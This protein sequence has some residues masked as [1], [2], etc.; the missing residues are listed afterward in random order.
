MRLEVDKYLNVSYTQQTVP[1]E[2]QGGKVLSF[3]CMLSKEFTNTAARV[4]VRS[5]APKVFWRCGKCSCAKGDI[6][7][8]A[9]SF[10]HYIVF[11]QNHQHCSIELSNTLPDAL[12][13]LLMHEAQ[14][15]RFTESSASSVSDNSVNACGEL[16]AFAT[17]L[18]FSAGLRVSHT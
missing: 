18:P 10:V 13:W 2:V 15:K 4:N 6:I 5:S 3:D 9:L 14:M 12:H 16:T 8:W 17:S 1:C 7:G 11:R